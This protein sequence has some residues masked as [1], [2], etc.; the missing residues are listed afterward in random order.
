MYRE[1]GWTE[2]HSSKTGQ[3]VFSK[4]LSG[5]PIPALMVKETASVS[6]EAV[7]SAIEDAGNYESFLRGVYLE[8][9]HLLRRSPGVIE[10]YQYL[11]LPFIAD[12]HYIYRMVKS[13]NASDAHVRLDW[14]LVPRDSE[15]SEFLDS[16]AAKYGDP[17]YPAQN[18]GGWE[19]REQPEGNVVV[20]YRLYVDAAGWVP[21]FLMARANRITAP[22]MVTH[23][24]QESIRRDSR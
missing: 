21:G 17:I 23:M 6:S 19:I 4:R 10:G 13:G 7:I 11:N 16:M 15:Y 12:R 8:R 20:S 18:V 24:I 2:I 5:F 1:S 9:S 14:T 22:K 3:K